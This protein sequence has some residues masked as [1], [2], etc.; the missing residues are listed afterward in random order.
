MGH[1]GKEFPVLRLR[2]GGAGESGIRSLAVSR[3]QTHAVR[4]RLLV[5]TMVGSPALGQPRVEA[6][7]R[8]PDPPASDVLW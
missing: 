6:D 3:G 1:V 7:E 2:V 5:N 4:K 8:I